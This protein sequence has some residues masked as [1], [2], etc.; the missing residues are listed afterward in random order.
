MVAVSPVITVIIPMHRPSHLLPKIRAVI[1]TAS[2]PIQTLIVLNNPTSDLQVST[3]APN[4][5]V[6]FSPRQGRGYAF[7]TGISQAKG[8]VILLL[9]ADTV[10]PI[11]WD[12]AILKALEKPQVVGGGF[13]LTY[14][15]PKW[16]LTY[17]T[18]LIDLVFRVTGELYGDRGMFVRTQTLQKCL[19]AM[20]VPLFEDVKLSKCMRSHGKIVMLKDKI[21]ASTKEFLKHGMFGNIKRYV[22]CRLWYA[23]GGT[24]QQLYKAYYKKK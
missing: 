18:H 3:Q 23:L 14:D 2:V 24:P 21:T 15:Q 7:L 10:P 17:G 11:N 5:E 4:E 8:K 6:I 16:Y 12:K 22:T 19:G 9:H 1:A 20:D 13:S